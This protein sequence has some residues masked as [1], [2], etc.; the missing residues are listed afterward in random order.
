[1]VILLTDT[2][3][4]AK[5]VKPSPS[6]PL[7]STSSH[8]RTRYLHTLSCPQ[9]TMCTNPF[10]LIRARSMRRLACWTTKSYRTGPISSSRI[11][12]TVLITH[13][14]S[15]KVAHCALYVVDNLRGQRLPARLGLH[16]VPQGCG[17]VW[18]LANVCHPPL[19]GIS[20]VLSLVHVS[21]LSP[22]LQV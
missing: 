16:Q 11:W 8:C 21:V 20:W 10:L 7:L 9:Q 14:F 5:A 6:R 15:V 13:F 4:L 3:L 18:C 2:T 22:L 19:Q 12:Y 17:L 1:M